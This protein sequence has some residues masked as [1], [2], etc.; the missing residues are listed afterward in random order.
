M[1]HVKV[2]TSVESF[3]LHSDTIVSILSH[4]FTIPLRTSIA[5]FMPEWAAG[6][7]IKLSDF[8]T[9]VERGWGDGKEAAMLSRMS[10][11]SVLV[12]GH[13]IVM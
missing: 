3:V 1:Y 11:P 9:G 8:H 5:A 12:F 4:A 2:W 10:R 13:V 7:A 6:L